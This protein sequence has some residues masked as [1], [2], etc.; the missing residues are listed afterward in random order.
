MQDRDAVQRLF[1][2]QR[3]PDILPAMSQAARMLVAEGLISREQLD[4]ATMLQATQ[5]GTIDSHLIAAGAL[6]SEQFVRFLVRRFP[7]VHWPRNRFESLPQHVIDSISPRVAA[8]LRVMPLSRSGNTLVLG[9][10][11]PSRNHAIQEV[12]HYSGTVVQPV[13]I[14]NTDLAWALRRYYPSVA[15]DL[16]TEEVPVPLT[17]RVTR[18]FEA[19]GSTPPPEPG[20]QAI[21]LVNRAVFFETRP[22]RASGEP[23]PD[24]PRSR[25]PVTVSPIRRAGGSAAGTYGLA[26]P[27]AR[28]AVTTAPVRPAVTTT[29]VRQ[30][31]GAAPARRAAAVPAP[32]PPAPTAPEPRPEP[33]RPA[34]PAVVVDPIRTIG[35]PPRRMSSTPPPPTGYDSW[36][37]GHR[38]DATPSQSPRRRGSHPL[39]R[40]RSQR[41]A[42]PDSRPPP[43][44]PTPPPAPAAAVTAPEPEQARPLTEGALIAAIDQAGDRDQ[45]IGL[46]LEYLG[47]F[48][49]R[50]VFFVVKSSEIRGFDIVGSLTSRDAIRSFWIPTAAP[51]TLRAVVASAQI[52]HGPLSDSPADSVLGAA[53]GGKPGVALIMPVTIRERVVGLLYADR[54]EIDALPWGRLERL[55]RAVADNLSRLISRSRAR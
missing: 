34:G 6:T 38:P 4:R 32:S 52:H 11:D 23:P 50:A 48:A 24:A 45:I 3:R 43:Q 37:P 1:S 14:S 27:P 9:L 22:L 17:Q 33:P 20:A 41:D 46:A 28:Q 44:P 55:T 7:V 29:P 25:P 35:E 51:S 36:G 15:G 40:S 54:L 26:A 19:W 10:T 42:R 31:T 21:P 12:A 5:G 47:R 30:L 8:T 39:S 53:L 16:S 13:V 18:E 2:I 49:G